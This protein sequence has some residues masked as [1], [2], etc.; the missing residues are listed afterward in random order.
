MSNCD[1]PWCLCRNFMYVGG[2]R[3]RCNFCQQAE[4]MVFKPDTSTM[5]LNHFKVSIKFRPR[6]T[7]QAR[8]Y[9]LGF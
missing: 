9:R 8:R 3:W 4:S 2:D 6:E 7:E 5:F 1:K